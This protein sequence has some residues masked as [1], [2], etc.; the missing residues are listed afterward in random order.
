MNIIIQ[1]LNFDGF[2]LKNWNIFMFSYSAISIYVWYVFEECDIASYKF[3]LYF[4][5][6]TKDITFEKYDMYN[7][8]RIQYFNN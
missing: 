6:Y 1:Q 4:L 8:I 5:I 2:D 3:C 7:L